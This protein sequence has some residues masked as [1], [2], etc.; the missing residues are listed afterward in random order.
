MMSDR[1]VRRY[2]PDRDAQ[3]QALV[4]LLTDS[5]VSN[6]PRSEKGTAEPAPF[7]G[8]SPGG[9]PLASDRSA[10]DSRLVGEVGHE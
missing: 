2:A 10:S 5:Q 6:P 9:E 7:S 1:I 4:Y 8:G 3:I